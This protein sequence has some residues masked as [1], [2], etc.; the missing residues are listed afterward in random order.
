VRAA[1]SFSDFLHGSVPSHCGPFLS[2]VFRSVSPEAGR[3]H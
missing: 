2:S 1:D 3:S